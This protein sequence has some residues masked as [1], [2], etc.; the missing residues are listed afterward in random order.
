MEYFKREWTPTRS[1]TGCATKGV[2]LLV[3]VKQHTWYV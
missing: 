1:I 3:L 2:A